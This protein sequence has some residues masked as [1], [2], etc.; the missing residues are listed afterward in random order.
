M[1]IVG[2][3]YPWAWNN[4]WYHMHV[5]LRQGS[6][7]AVCVQNTYCYW[8]GQKRMWIWT[9]RTNHYD[10]MLAFGLVIQLFFVQNVSMG[11]RWKQPMNFFIFLA[12]DLVVCGCVDS[13]EFL[14]RSLAPGFRTLHGILCQSVRGFALCWGRHSRKWCGLRGGETNWFQNNTTKDLV[15][16]PGLGWSVIGW[17]FADQISRKIFVPLGFRSA[18]GRNRQCRAFQLLH[19]QTVC[20]F[21]PN[22]PS[23][24][25]GCCQEDPQRRTSSEQDFC[26]VYPS[27][28][29]AFSIGP[30]FVWNSKA[31]AAMFFWDCCAQSA[32]LVGWL[33]QPHVWFA[34]WCRWQ[35]VRHA[36]RVKRSL[37]QADNNM[38]F[39]LVPSFST[40]A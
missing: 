24:D 28:I 30:V 17:T 13:I 33:D 18:R 11:A 2:G 37:V 40:G 3:E 36:G 34:L 10:V 19:I 14:C 31:P 20:K 22:I 23:S 12:R 1:K 39:F 8:G 32:I 26:I 16:L 7:D 21:A 27:A 29:L 6:H 35:P 4:G 25:M 38:F 15:W 5:S 9:T